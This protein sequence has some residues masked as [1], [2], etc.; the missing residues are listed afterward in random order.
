[1]ARVTVEDCVQRVEN[2]FDLVL[3]DLSLPDAEGS[4]TIAQMHREVPQIP[5]IALTGLDD[6]A[7]IA[8]AVKHGAED[9]LVKGTFKTDVLIRAMLYA[10]DRRRAPERKPATPGFACGAP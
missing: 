3:L 8:N 7:I 10:I 1:M 2:R 6:P 5:I 9:Y 4:E